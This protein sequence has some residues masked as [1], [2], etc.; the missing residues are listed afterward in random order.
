MQSPRPS[1]FRRTLGLLRPLIE[2]GRAQLTAEWR[3]HLLTL[4][5][6]VWGAAAVVFLLSTGA[7]FYA[8]LDTGFKKTG[9]RQTMV[10][11][12]YTTSETGGARPGR[13]IHLTRDDLDRLR[14]GVPSARFIAGQTI[15][16]VVAVRTLLHT[17]NSVVGA[18]T[19]DLQYI[20][21]LRVAHGR[22]FDDA[23]ERAGRAVAVLGAKIATIFFGA[24][25]PLNRTLQI[26]GRPFE[27]IGVLA[28]KGQQLMVEWA[29]HDD[30][31]FIPL[32]AARPIFGQGDE[33][34]IV[35]AKPRR[36][37][38]IPAM[39]AEL[40]GVLTSWHHVPAGDDEAIHLD[41]VTDW[42][43]PFRNIG[44]GLQM[45]LGFIGTVALAMAGVG[46]ANL[47]IAIVNDRRMELAVRRAC[48]ARRSDVLLQL[49][50]ETMVIVFAGGAIGVGLGV[51]IALDVGLLPLPE[52][53][54][55]PRISLSVIL[56]TFGVLAAVGLAAGIVPA[57][58]ASQVDP[59]TA[60]RVT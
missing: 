4:A 10:V 16:S 21:E 41:S 9:D 17:R 37:D 1:R 40:R 45:L 56:T 47:M 8:F 49:L 44:R 52:M 42:I 12:E 33:V 20:Q 19:P 5:G 7:G 14:A 26:E 50:V 51:A 32:R 54:P 24:D 60:M 58:L 46:V 36:L 3:R 2:D 28:R 30:M 27:V 13:R 34:D 11:G 22:F 57:R 48:G 53:I 35:Y 15:R 59:G 23:D 31:I 29:P 6:I 55:T 39:Q 43:E 38:D 25:D 18:L